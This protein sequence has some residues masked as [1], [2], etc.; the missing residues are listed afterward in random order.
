MI[1]I[2][3]RRDDSQEVTDRIFRRLCR[4]FGKDSFF[5]DMQAIP[6][7]RDFRQV[8]RQAI[9]QSAAVLVVIGRDWLTIRDAQGRQRLTLGNDFVRA[10]I[11]AALSLGVP[12]IPLLVG[13]AEMPAP[14]DLPGDIRD[15]AFRNAAVVRGGRDF[16]R[17]MKRV[18]RDLAAYHPHSPRSARL[19]LVFCAA[20]AAASAIL[21]LVIGLTGRGLP[22]A[23][24]PA[25]PWC[26]LGWHAAGSRLIPIQLVTYSLVHQDVGHYVGNMA[27]LFLVASFLRNAVSLGVFVRAYLLGGILGGLGYLLL[28]LGAA[29]GVPMVG[30]GMA[31]AAVLGAV[32]VYQPDYSVQLFF[33]WRVKMKWVVLLFFILFMATAAQRAAQ[34]IITWE[35]CGAI[36]LM[37]GVLYAIVE[38]SVHMRI[39]E[40]LYR[41]GK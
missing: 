27:M 22:L 3:Y 1:F 37:S 8:V 18:V 15:L 32:A 2:S 19:I 33:C 25:S 13:G 14:D 7:G 36:G 4:Q 41:H 35:G 17:D 24:N 39:G 6:L 30:A 16:E 31:V 40:W 28:S 21:S 12:V 20:V 9:G 11:G 29:R 5:K 10:E 26:A 23:Q 34:G 38:K